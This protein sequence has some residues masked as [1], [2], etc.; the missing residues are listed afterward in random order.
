MYLGLDDSQLGAVVSLNGPGRTEC[1][2][3]PALSP[4]ASLAAVARVPR[5]ASSSFATSVSCVSTRVQEETDDEV[6]TTYA[7][8]PPCLLGL[9]CLEEI[10]WRS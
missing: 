2:T 1:F 4:T 10:R 7:C 5:D 8:C 3:S 6:S 9:W